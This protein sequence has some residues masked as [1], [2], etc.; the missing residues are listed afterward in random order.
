MRKFF[1]KVNQMITA[2]KEKVCGVQAAMTAKARV[3]AAQTIMLL[4]SARAEN[5]VDSGIKILIAVVIGALLLAGLYALFGDTILP[6]VTEKVEEMFNF[7]G[8]FFLSLIAC[9]FK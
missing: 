7:S 9:L 2:F 1:A 5:F 4:E 3:K 8:S 6:T